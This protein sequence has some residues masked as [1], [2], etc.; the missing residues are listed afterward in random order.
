MIL[1][2]TYVAPSDIEGVGVF[3]AGPIAKGT[4]LWRLDRGF[5]RLIRREDLEKRDP[6][7]RDFADRYGYPYP[8]DP[9]LLVV[10]LDN[11]RFMNHST[12]PNTCFNDPDYGYSLID[13]A[14][15]E[16]ITCDYAEFEPGFEILP[17]RVFMSRAKSVSRVAT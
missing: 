7:F 3:A 9:T 2:P 12:T 11:G 1:V 15:D 14:A 16:E 5:D 13:I 17:G 6:V 10:E 4:L 8:H